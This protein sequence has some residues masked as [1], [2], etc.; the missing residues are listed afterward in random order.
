MLIEM[1]KVGEA[2]TGREPYVPA[3]ADEDFVTGCDR[4]AKDDGGRRMQ[5]RRP[6]RHWRASQN[7]LRRGA[8]SSVV[9]EAGSAGE[10]DPGIPRSCSGPAPG[11]SRRVSK[12]ISR[13]RAARASEKDLF[14]FSW[15]GPVSCL[16]LAV[17]GESQRYRGT[18]PGTAALNRSRRR[19]SFLMTRAGDETDPTADWPAGTLWG[20]TFRLSSRTERRALHEYH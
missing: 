11:N 17:G 2:E 8:A 5:L 7:Q 19:R 6:G 14:C 10:E 20:Y 18:P 15:Q 4:F 13:T 3:T 1:I 9:L 16:R 12:S